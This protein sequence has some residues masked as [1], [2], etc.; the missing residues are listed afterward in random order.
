MIKERT[1]L[2]LA[3]LSGVAIAFI[4]TRP[5]WDDTGISVMMILIASFICG[6]LSPRRPWLMAL[7]V[8]I[9]IPLFN[10]LNSRNIGSL[11]A[12]LPAFVGAYAGYF[13]KR[14]FAPPTL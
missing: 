14:M 3:V 1:A 4:D 9:W 11:L 5:H 13:A 8:G 10:I 6:I 7:S 12:L 2:A